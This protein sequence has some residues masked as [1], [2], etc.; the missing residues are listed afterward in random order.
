MTTKMT[1][2]RKAMIDAM[3]ARGFSPR[4]HESY[5]Y[6][7]SALAG[8]YHRRPDQ[9]G[10]EQIAQFF[11]YLANERDLSGASCRLYLNG[12]RFFYLQVLEWPSFDVVITIPKRAQRIPELLTR[13]EVA[14]IVGACAQGKHRTLLLTCYG[15]GLRV[16][17][18]V[19]L[20]VRHID[21]EREL[22]R[23]E[24]GKGAKDRQVILP[25]E[26]LQ[27]LRAYWRAYRPAKWLFPGRDPE[28]A[29]S[30]ATAQKV[31]QQAKRRA[32]IEK[33]GGIHSL[34]HAYAT[35]Q[36]ANGMG[37]IQLQEQLGHKHLRTTE[38][39]LHWVP[40]HRESGPARDLIAELGL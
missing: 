31:F 40:S 16:S 19:S 35:H 24:Q 4:T 7:V 17:E 32:G 25:P 6:A 11:E 39:Y 5:L 3:H 38:R 22:L 12:V 18:L 27:A 2:L 10:A 9:L 36:L 23:I 14:A 15:C 30:I 29:L 13:A 21:G 8:Y 28:K 1:P 20:K 26:L 33:V 37:L 34:R